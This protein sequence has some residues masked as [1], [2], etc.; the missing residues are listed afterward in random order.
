MS[1]VRDL[2]ARL[3]SYWIMAFVSIGVAV[4]LWR[5]RSGKSGS[6]VAT[7]LL[8]FYIAVS[9]SGFT[10]VIQN[11][12]PGMRLSMNVRTWKKIFRPLNGLRFGS[13]PGCHLRLMKFDWET[14]QDNPLTIN[15]IRIWDDRPLLTTYGQLQEIRTYYDFYDVDIDRYMIDENRQSCCQGRDELR[16]CFCASTAWINAHF[17]TRMGMD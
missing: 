13:D 9:A 16:Q 5:S 2:N 1:R 3:P 7:A 8:P 4:W 15:N 12:R 10:E 11:L 6:S 14:V 17:H